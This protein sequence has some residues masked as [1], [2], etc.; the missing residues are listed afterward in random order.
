[1]NI[2][3]T[4]ANGFIGKRLL[5]R[6]LDAGH[7]VYAV[8][9]DVGRFPENLAG[10]PNLHLVEMDFLKPAENSALPA[11][12]DAA[13]YLIHSMASSIEDFKELE[14]RAAENFVKLLNAT[15]ARQVIYL[16]GIV[17]A[18]SLSKHLTSRLNVEN[19]LRGANAS[20]TA[21]RAGIIVGSGSASFE[22]TRDL[23]A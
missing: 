13:Y 1:M 11:D 7:T 5:P 15:N 17:N 18:D 19:I 12:I 8:V 9:R 2:L 23:V 21:L 16:G 4:G 20:L 3:L 6:L 22:N 10:H 14:T